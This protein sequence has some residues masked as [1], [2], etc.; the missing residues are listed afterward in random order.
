MIGSSRYSSAPGGEAVV[1]GSRLLSVEHEAQLIWRLRSRFAAT[2]LR[3]MFQR[4]RLRLSLV[5]GL[6][7]FFWAGLFL[8]FHEGFTFLAKTVGPAG[9]MHTETVQAIYNVFFASLTVMLVFSSGIIL[10]SSLYRSPDTAFLLTTPIRPQRIVLYKF[11]E[12]L[13]YSSWGFLLL[14]SP[15]LV[16]YGV[17]AES[18][19][20]YYCLL[21][22]YMLAF[23]YIPC[24]IGAIACVLI[25]HRLPR[26]RLLALSLLIVAMI[27]LTVAALW[28]LFGVQEGELLT[29]IW[30]R[31][32]LG[33]LQFAEQRLLPSW[34][35]SSGLLESSRQPDPAAGDQPIAHSVLFLSVLVSNS[36]MLHLLMLWIAERCFRASYSGLHTQQSRRRRNELAWIDRF[37]LFVTMPLSYHVRL[38]IVKDLRVFRR[39]PVQWSQFLIFFGLLTMYFVNIRRFSYDMNYAGW[40]SMVSFLNLAVV[41]LILSTFTTRFIFPMISLE[42]N[43]FWILGLLPVER[44]TILWGK[45]LFASIGSLIPCAILILVSDVMLRVPL[46]VL[47]IHQ[48]ICFILCTGLSGIA[49]G[50]GATMPDLSEESPSKI[51]A[52]FGGT[53]TLVLSAMYIVTV[54]LL[55]AVPCHFYLARQALGAGRV[56]GS[57]SDLMML[58]LGIVSAVALG[59]V[60]TFVPLL[61][62]MRAFRKMEF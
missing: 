45:F 17:V 42:G 9:A 38:L 1:S 30:F 41:G 33:R 28:S 25:V 24:A 23:A 53:L 8:L 39:D 16:A 62:G 2:A 57:S 36:L 18:S 55:T 26:I 7:T 50:L 44:D 58:L 27:V 48:V 21:L 61:S 51:A 43:R 19:W 54:V 13:I 37:A 10:Y 40:V 3:Q 22:P 6:S 12:A 5:V 52:G 49:V 14:G 32:T 4:A 15:M 46:L 11:Q 59:I 47:L 35:L 60:A 20:Y 29:P 56:H 31:D 34:W